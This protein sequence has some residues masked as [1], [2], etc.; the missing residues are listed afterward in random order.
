MRAV[1]GDAARVALLDDVGPAKIVCTVH[2]RIHMHSCAVRADERQRRVS[3]LALAGL[4]PSLPQ[5]WRASLPFQ[6]C[7][8]LSRRA[9][10][11]IG[12]T[13]ALSRSRSSHR[14][15]KIQDYGRRILNTARP[16]EALL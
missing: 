11:A 4:V 9:T 5:A 16:C 10:T 1:P 13:M 14:R 15:H 2:I 3:S 6:Q 12:V 7:Y 8:C